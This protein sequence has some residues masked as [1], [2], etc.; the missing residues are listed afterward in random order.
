MLYGAF[1]SWCIKDFALICIAM[2]APALLANL[3][4]IVWLPESPLWLHSKQKTETLHK[5]LGYVAKVNRV[6]YTADEKIEPSTSTVSENTIRLLFTFSRA[7]TQR[8]FILLFS[9]LTAS[10]CYWG[11]SFNVGDLIGNLYINQLLICLIDLINRPFNY[12]GVKLFDRVKFLRIC[13]LGM[14][15]SAVV[16]MVPY[17]KEIF[18]SFNIRKISALVGRMIADLYFSTI[19]LYTAEVLP[20]V[21]R[22]TGLGLC[23]SFARIGSIIAPFVIVANTVSPLI[24][25][26]AILL[27][28]AVCLVG[29]GYMPET[30]DIHLPE[31]MADMMRLIEGRVERN[32]PS[33]ARTDLR[34]LLDSDSEDEVYTNGGVAVDIQAETAF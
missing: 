25:F 23:S 17:E 21:S 22:A 4:I 10:F 32:L 27:L 14:I 33:A 28:S 11:L 12:Y 34:G 13:N 1:L 9:W 16:C 8:M 29:F 15:I 20:T 3:A 7:T 2:T 31:T 6:K 18:P 26:F 19:Y 30:R 5:A 24:N